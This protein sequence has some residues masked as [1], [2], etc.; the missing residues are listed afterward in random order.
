MA[1]Y[2]VSDIHGNLN[3][4]KDLLHQTTIDFSTDKLYILGDM[5]DWGNQSLDTLLF[6]MSLN[7]QYPENVL[8]TMGNHEMLLLSTLQGN[9]DARRALRCNNGNKTRREVVKLQY[10]NSKLYS[11]LKRWLFT[12]PIMYED[13]KYILTHSVP[14]RKGTILSSDYYTMHSEFEEAKVNAVWM[15]ADAGTAC[16]DKT[17]ISGHTITRN[18]RVYVS[19]RHIKIDCGAKLIGYDDDGKLALVLFNDD[20]TYK[21]WY[22]N[23]V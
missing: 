13:G 11:E 8:V 9:P 2:V 15:R 19:N 10:K 7:K 14:P 3:A 18:Y 17:L 20:D 1:F 21:I 6:I 4:F 16:G 23:K 22:S 5:I 12:L